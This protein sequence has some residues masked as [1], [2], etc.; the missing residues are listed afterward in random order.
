VGATGTTTAPDALTL[1]GRWKRVNECPQ[2]VKALEQPVLRAIAPSVFG[3]H[4]R[5]KVRRS[6]RERTISVTVR[7]RSFI[8]TSSPGWSVGSLDENEQQVDDGTYEIL[9]EG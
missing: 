3:E 7:N 2:L 6:W 4:S 8:T 9:D 1:V 5:M